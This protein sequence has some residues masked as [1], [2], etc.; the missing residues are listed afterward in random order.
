MPPLQPT[1]TSPHSLGDWRAYLP[2]ASPATWGTLL[3]GVVIGLA[4]GLFIGWQ[5]LPVQWTDAWPGDLS[6]EARAQ[7]L[8]AVAEAYVYYSTDEAAEIARNRLFDLNNNLEQ[9]IADAVDFF[10]ATRPRNFNTTITNLGLLA[11]RLG[12]QAPTVETATQVSPVG[13][14]VR[15]WVN[16]TLTALAA[17]LLAGGGIYIVNRMQQRRRHTAPDRLEDDPGGFEEEEPARTPRPAPARYPFMRPAAGAAAVRAGT[18]VPPA[19][20]SPREQAE[21]DDEDYGF[22]DETPGETTYRP[23]RPIATAADYSLR[24][25]DF[26]DDAPY[27]D[28]DYS[29]SRTGGEAREKFMSTFRAEEDEEAY[30]PTAPG[31]PF[32]DLDDDRDDERNPAALPLAAPATGLP[33]RAAA[34]KTPRI[35][36]TYTATYRAGFSEGSRSYIQINNIVDPET[37]RTVGE[38]GMAVHSV[39]GILDNDPDAVIAMEVWLMDKM[40]ES[41][42]LSQD[43][44]LLSEYAYDQGLEGKITRGRTT[45]PRPIIPQ[46]GRTEFDIKGPSLILHCEV[47]EAV[48]T[49]SGPRKGIFESLVIEMTVLARS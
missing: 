49:K 2:P 23:A 42:V 5:V 25:E 8:A 10:A 7:Y 41:D 44:V 34:A 9:E 32:Q 36:Q 27:A 37:G 21:R 47:L 18:G 29:V 4:I 33:A 26:D 6:R 38:C 17:L 19:T 43:R 1:R 46:A 14:T 30:S 3:A 20:V 16:W 31:D 39:N 15:A 24:D 11:Q 45:D 40:N 13:D 35:L 12:V 48:Y 22:S 28:D